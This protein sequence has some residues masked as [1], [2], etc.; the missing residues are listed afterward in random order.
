MRS[1]RFAVALMAVIVAVLAP[2]CEAGDR[3]RAGSV[4][5]R[6]SGLS[7]WT[8]RLDRGWQTGSGTPMT[9]AGNGLTSSPVRR[10]SSGWVLW[11]PKTVGRS[12]S[13]R[14]LFVRR[15]AERTGSRQTF[16]GRRSGPLISSAPLMCQGRSKNG[17]SSAFVQPTMPH[18]RKKMPDGPKWRRFSNSLTSGDGGIS[19][20][21]NHRP[22]LSARYRV[23][24]FRCGSRR[25][26]AT[27]VR[28][29]RCMVGIQDGRLS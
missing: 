24:V 25:N 6:C 13:H 4:G 1:D 21:T 10:L 5:P 2:G 27:G 12:R 11:I 29:Q 9:V 20:K 19:S 23:L 14:P 8:P 18:Y 15:T 26:W 17:S 28:N 16:Q 7:R 3:G 22:A